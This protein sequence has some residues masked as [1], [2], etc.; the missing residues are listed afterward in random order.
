MHSHAKFLAKISTQLQDK[1]FE[2]FHRQALSFEGK[3]LEDLIRTWNNR[4]S[5]RNRVW[6]ALADRDL[7]VERLEASL[8]KVNSTPSLFFIDRKR[9]VIYRCPTM[10]SL[11]QLVDREGGPDQRGS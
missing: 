5:L 11:K 6:S 4:L 2:E 8:V 9:N 10:T 7:R 3:P 1:E